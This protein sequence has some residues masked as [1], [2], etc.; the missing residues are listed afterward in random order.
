[1]NGE[2]IRSEEVVHKRVCESRWHK[3]MVLKEYQAC[4][5]CQS[6]SYHLGLGSESEKVEGDENED[7]P[8]REEDVTLVVYAQ[9]L[10]CKIAGKALAQIFDDDSLESKFPKA[11]IGFRGIT[12]WVEKPGIIK[13][14]YHGWVLTPKGKD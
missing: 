1:M 5:Y 9:A 2:I 6:E 10:P 13:K 8:R 3:E 7:E 11:A 4:P 14:G 12:G